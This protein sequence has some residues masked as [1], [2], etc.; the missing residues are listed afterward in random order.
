MTGKKKPLECVFCRGKMKKGT[1]PFHIDRKGI[2]V[3]FCAVPA[4]VCQ[5]CGQ[6][7]FEESVARVIEEIVEAVDA[8]SKKLWMRK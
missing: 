5:Q 2:H 8:K 1:I 4:L 3:T 7:M 6:G